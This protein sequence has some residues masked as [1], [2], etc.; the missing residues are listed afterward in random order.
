MIDFFLPGENNS[1]NI[2]ASVQDFLQCMMSTPL[3]NIRQQQ[4]LSI[5][6]STDLYAN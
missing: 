4:Q 5:I 3:T 6:N 2:C 1:F